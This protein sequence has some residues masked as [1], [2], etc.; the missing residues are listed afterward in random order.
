MLGQN[1][2]YE[3]HYDV[4]RSEDEVQI[5]EM[6]M[7]DVNNDVTTI[8]ERAYDQIKDNRLTPLGF[9]TSHAVY[10]TTKLAGSVLNDP[11]FNFDGFEGSGTDVVHYHVPLNGY[12]GGIKITSRVY[13]Q[14][15]PP[16]YMQE[17]FAVSTP[18]IDAFEVMYNNADQR[19]TLVAS[20][21]IVSIN[22]V[23]GIEEVAANSFEVY[24]NPSTNGMVRFRSNK[25]NEI[26]AISVYNVRGQLQSSLSKYPVGGIELPAKAG[27]YLVTI[28]GTF[29]TEVHRVVRR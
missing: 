21:S 27:I 25:L 9:T 14:T 11:D 18:E 5:Y 24:P 6:V 3:P 26:D 10:D 7:G 12:N 16:R 29:G 8:L 22:V 17:M 2:T 4:I 20:D 19:P 13:Y 23:T 28:E 15:A 1:S